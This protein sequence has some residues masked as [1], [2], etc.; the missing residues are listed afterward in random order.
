MATIS[1]KITKKV[2]KLY[3]KDKLSVQDVANKLNVS[4]DDVFYDG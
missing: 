4:I 3:Y 1:E 2:K